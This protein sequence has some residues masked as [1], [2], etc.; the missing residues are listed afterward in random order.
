MHDRSNAHASAAIDKGHAACD[1]WHEPTRVFTVC[2]DPHKHQPGPIQPTVVAGAA[3]S[4]VDRGF[5]VI[6]LRQ[7][8]DVHAHFR[9]ADGPA[10]LRPRCQHWLAAT[11]CVLH[12]HAVA[13]GTGPA[14]HQA[15]QAE[16]CRPKQKTQVAADLEFRAT[17][18]LAK[19]AGSVYADDLARERRNTEEQEAAH[20]GISIGDTKCQGHKLLPI[21]GNAK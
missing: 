21:T 11:V 16:R 10:G 12:V 13:R 8:C 14:S 20:V 9:G 6:R 18:A 4:A 19:Y 7:L 17:A 15:Q 5:A 3:G 2:G 1:L